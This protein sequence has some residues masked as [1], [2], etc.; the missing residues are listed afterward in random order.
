MKLIDRKNMKRISIFFLF[1]GC[2]IGYAQKL[3]TDRDSV[4]QHLSQYNIYSE[5]AKTMNAEILQILDELDI[6]RQE[7]SLYA[8]RLILKEAESEASGWDIT[9]LRKIFARAMK[10]SPQSREG[11]IVKAEVLISSVWTEAPLGFEVIAYTQ[12]KETLAILESLDSEPPAEIYEYAL[13]NIATLTAYFGDYDKSA[14]YLEKI[15][16]LHNNK[17]ALT[18]RDKV[19][20]YVPTIM[21]LY[22]TDVDH[23]ILFN[24][25]QKL[26]DQIL[27]DPDPSYHYSYGSSTYRVLEYC[28]RT[29]K[30]GGKELLEN[31]MTLSNEFLN[32]YQ[33][34][35]D[36]NLRFHI[37]YVRHLK[38]EFLLLDDKPLEALKLNTELIARHKEKATRR[39]RFTYAQRIRILLTLDRVEEAIQLVP[40]TLNSFHNGAEELKDDYS[41]F[42]T[43]EF[44]DYVSTFLDLSDAFKEVKSDNTELSKIVSQFNKLA[45]NQFEKSINNKLTTSKTR[46]LFQRIISNMLSVRSNSEDLYSFDK[47]FLSTVE[48]LSNTLDWQE[49]LQQRSFSDFQ[50]LDILKIEQTALNDKLVDARLDENDTLV[51]KYELQL[52]Q[53]IARMNQERDKR[54]QI[55]LPIFNTQD[56]QESL[57]DSEL[58]LKYQTVEDDLYLFAVSRNNIAIEKIGS[59][60]QVVGVAQRYLE[61]IKTRNNEKKS[62]MELRRLLIPQDAI[63]F[64]NLNIIPN[65]FLYKI[66]FES[67]LDENNTYL[68]ENHSILYAPYISLLKFQTTRDGEITKDPDTDQLMI[69]TPSYDTINVNEDRIAVRG[70][71][72]RLEGAASESRLINAIFSN[73]SFTNHT[74]TKEN[75]KRHAP[76]AHIL[77]L[78]MHANLDPKTPELS[79]FVFTE[80]SGD[81]LLY[82]QELYGMNLKADMAVLS[83]CNTGVGKF[84][85]D[86]GVVSL[87]SAFIQAGVPTTVSSL[88]SAPDKATEKI[89]LE[90][91]KQLKAGKPKAKALQTA[92]KYYLETT[93]N[94]ELQ[95]PFYWAGFVI[96]GNDSPVLVDSSLS[97]QY[98]ILIIVG[99]CILLAI[100]LFI[101]KK[102]RSSSS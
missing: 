59:T 79:H 86:K 90:F 55:D 94:K 37:D 96:N 43:R 5:E 61:A 3:S 93:G 57:S 13:D 65:E 91:Y 26:N 42:S 25:L 8:A 63:A 69:F 47:T 67:L 72:Y 71:E 22:Q 33:N 31:G 101:L 75:F 38:A 17:S 45:I 36:P 102:R 14:Y 89:M 68:L 2:S 29:Y 53:H 27:E 1:I 76:A 41:N 46:K 64:T 28:L 50:D 15:K 23:E 11:K 92:K 30:K 85:S 84:K 56:F 44:L 49:F 73:S 80:G 18:S 82:L 9:L 32:K 74:A 97:T 24:Y 52:E 62:S 35:A 99:I 51:K 58:T 19:N 70:N 81:N 60:D 78:S 12:A 100:I 87:H 95:H 4:L 21:S 39:V 34:S 40:V 20:H 16:Q 98:I 88:W 6:E 54:A 7:D 10:M 66:P 83:A 77:H 48:N